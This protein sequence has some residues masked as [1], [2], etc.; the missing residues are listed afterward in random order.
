MTIRPIAKIL[1]A[2][3]FLRGSGGFV[4]CPVEPDNNGVVDMLP[5]Q[6]KMIV[7]PGRG[8]CEVV[9]DVLAA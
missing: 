1:S 8:R 9:W 6:E 5:L 4:V 3:T 7:L 2:A